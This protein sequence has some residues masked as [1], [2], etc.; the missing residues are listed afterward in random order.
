MD[1]RRSRR[2]SLVVLAATACLAALACP[3]HAIADARPARAIS[4]NLCTDELVLRLAEP[5]RIASVTWLARAL[6]VDGGLLLADEPTTALDPLHQ[7]QVMALLRATVQRGRGVIVV[8]HDLALAMCFCNRLVLLAD[9]RVFDDG[10]P[11]RV[12]TDHHLARA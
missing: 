7:L 6:A 1:R 3:G 2:R 5:D 11:G 10:P 8:L 12:P 9:G 4:L